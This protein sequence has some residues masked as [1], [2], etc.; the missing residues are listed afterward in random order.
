MNFKYVIDQL[1]FRKIN[2][3][4]HNV[5]EKYKNVY[6]EE[7]MHTNIDAA[8]D[9]MYQ[10]ENG[11]LRRT[12]SINR[13]KGYYMAN[14]DKWYFAYVFKNNTIYIIDAEYSANMSNNAYSEFN[15][16][17]AN[18]QLIQSGL[19]QNVDSIGISQSIKAE[20]QNIHKVV[21]RYKTDVFGFK[22][23]RD[24]NGLFN[25]VNTANNRYVSQVWCQQA[26]SLK[27]VQKVF[28]SLKSNIKDIVIFYFQTVN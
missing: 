12:P 6:S 20:S 14:T 18:Q 27:K 28:Y 11:L 3:F 9:S 21:A 7:M 1:C 13:W 24:T 2:S 8:I 4:Y 16:E 19:T 10:I 26:V 22:L 23:V 15:A 25:F 5:A 17:K